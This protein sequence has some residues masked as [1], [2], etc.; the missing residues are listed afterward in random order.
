MQVR[1][2]PSDA[3]PDM[4]ILRTMHVHTQ[5]RCSSNSPQDLI[6]SL[7]LKMLPS[8]PL[9]DIIYLILQTFWH[10]F[11]HVHEPETT[12]LSKQADLSL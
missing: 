8:T 5:Q 6:S 2:L 4:C 12:S 7:K 3:H 1:V 9:K 10:V 11:M